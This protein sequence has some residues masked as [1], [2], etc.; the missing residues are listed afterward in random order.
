MSTTTSLKLD[1]EESE[2]VAAEA[3][4][5]ARVLDEPARSA[6][7]RLAE[8]AAAGEVPNE[9][10]GTLGDVA[11]ASLEGG[12]ARRLYLAEGE[13]QLQR[14]FLR[15]PPGQAL[16]AS[17]DEVNHALTALSG[18]QLSGVKVAMRTPG[19]FTIQIGT[20]GMSLTLAVTP[21]SV[22]VDSVAIG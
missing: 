8:A 11:A 5:A 19:H 22:A 4:A 13:K 1:E 20:E 7:A 14:L 6:A 17:L 3:A 15:T 18:R 12:R 2:I 21:G 16:S 10:L 9:L